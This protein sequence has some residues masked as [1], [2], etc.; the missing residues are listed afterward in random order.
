MQLGVVQI[1][2]AKVHYINYN[3]TIYRNFDIIPILYMKDIITILEMIFT[4][5]EDEFLT[6]LYKVFPYLFL[7][8][9]KY[10][11]IC[12]KV[13]NSFRTLKDLDFK[14]CRNFAKHLPIEV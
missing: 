2:F 8:L 10:K 14:Y 13:V 6:A 11:R 7:I 9:M 3:A 1:E 12:F 4:H 5:K